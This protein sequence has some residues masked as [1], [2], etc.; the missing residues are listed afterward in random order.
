VI[1]VSR[2]FG[3]KLGY[4]KNMWESVSNSL[5]KVNISKIIGKFKDYTDEIILEGRSN[6]EIIIQLD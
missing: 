3:N 1:S 6:G 2:N 4:S 5:L